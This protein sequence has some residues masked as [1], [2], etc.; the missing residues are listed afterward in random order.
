MN[1]DLPLHLKEFCLPTEYAK[2]T[3]K[4]KRVPMILGSNAY[5]LNKYVRIHVRERKVCK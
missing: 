5:F 4:I 2:H 1:Y 3:M